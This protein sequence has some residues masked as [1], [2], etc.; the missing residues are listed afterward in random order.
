MDEV[1]SNKESMEL[2]GNA[3]QQKL[4]EQAKIIR[5][6]AQKGVIVASKPTLLGK[7]MYLAFFFGVMVPT[8][9]LL[10]FPAVRHQWI[11][12]IS[13]WWV[14][15]AQ[16]V[17]RSHIYRLPPPPPKPAAKKLVFQSQISIPVRNHDSNRRSTTASS[18][19]VESSQENDIQD[20][21]LEKTSE[22]IGAYELL[23]DKSKIAWDLK[24]G[25]ISG[26]GFRTWRLVKSSTPVFWVDIVVFL[27]S[28]QREVHLIWSVDM[29]KGTIEALSQAARDLEQA[30]SN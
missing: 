4:K 8:V 24:D 3:S 22:A 26:Y 29:E 21:I 13:E 27:A 6:L 9:Y 19:S 20:Q 16:D 30:K 18:V 12:K 5:G 7:I 23:L 1:A 2:D 14:D 25:K 28:S 15:A 10:I 11:I 17:T